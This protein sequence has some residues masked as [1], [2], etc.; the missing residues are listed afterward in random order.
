MPR[1]PLREGRAIATLA[2]IDEARQH[3]RFAIGDDALE[4]VTDPA[5]HR[6]GVR[7][8]PAIDHPFEALR[9]AVRADRQR[10]RRE[11]QQ[12]HEWQHAA[13]D[14]RGTGNRRECAHRAFS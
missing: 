12:P 9:I 14:R 1:A 10:G 4:H 5:L 3:G 11:L 6:G 2:R 8:R 13:V 7:N